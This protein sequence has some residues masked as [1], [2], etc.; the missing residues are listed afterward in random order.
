[1]GQAFN[2]RDNLE[3]SCRAQLGAMATQTALDLPAQAVWDKSAHL[4]QPGARRPDGVLAWP[5]MLHWLRAEWATAGVHLTTADLTPVKRA[6]RGLAIK[7]SSKIAT[8]RVQPAE[9]PR[10]LCGKQ[11]M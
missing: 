7:A 10:I 4:Y 6:Q 3:L 8:A 2:L 1:V 9:A 11:L 5:A